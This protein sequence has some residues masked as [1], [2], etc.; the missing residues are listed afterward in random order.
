MGGSF[1]TVGSVMFELWGMILLAP[2]WRPYPAN[3][4]V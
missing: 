3:G 1:R 2:G 4:V